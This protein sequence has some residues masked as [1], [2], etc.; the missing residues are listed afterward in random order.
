MDVRRIVK[1]IGHK[2]VNCEAFEQAGRYRITDLW[3]GETGENTT[4]IFK[5][6]RLDA[7]DN[8][9]WKVSVDD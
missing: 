8:V 7:C 1:M 3:T 6:E 9:T 5:V 4:G 2:M